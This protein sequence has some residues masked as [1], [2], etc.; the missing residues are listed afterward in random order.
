MFKNRWNLVPT[1]QAKQGKNDP[2]RRVASPEALLF[3]RR[4][5][6][7]REAPRLPRGP[8]WA[9]GTSVGRSA[10]GVARRPR[11]G[12]QHLAPKPWPSRCVLALQGQSSLPTGHWW[13]ERVSSAPFLRSRPGHAPIAGEEVQQV[14]P[15]EGGLGS[16]LAR[17]PARG[18][19]SRAPL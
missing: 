6:P 18:V 4:E 7:I 2:K 14:A 5:K 17:P 3:P 9:M 13:I 15:L 19:A 1:A 11:R 10:P 12:S 8:Y 16:P